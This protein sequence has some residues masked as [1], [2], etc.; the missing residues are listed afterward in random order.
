MAQDVEERRRA[1]DELM[2]YQQRDFEGLFEEMRG[3]PVTIRLLDPPLHEFLPS[4]EDPT[5][6]VEQARAERAATIPA[7]RYGTP[8]EFGAAC[9]FLCS[10]HAGYIV[11]QNLLLDGGAGNSTI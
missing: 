11:G 1:L 6:D 4:L 8:E 5:R 7:R 2:P 9:A 3:L 10:Q